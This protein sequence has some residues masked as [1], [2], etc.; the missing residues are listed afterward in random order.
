M[1]IYMIHYTSTTFM[2]AKFPWK[3]PDWHFSYSTFP[4]SLAVN[5][6]IRGGGW[7]F[8]LGGV[9]DFLIRI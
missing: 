2:P 8:S 3:T 9:L 4:F 7:D 1:F 5:F 6:R